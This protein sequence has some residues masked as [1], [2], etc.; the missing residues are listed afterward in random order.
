MI[1]IIRRILG[2]IFKSIQPKHGISYWKRRA[3]NF[4]VRSVLNISHKESE[5]DEVTAMQVREIFPHLLSALNGDE[6]VVLD[7]GC[8]PGRFTA[9]LAEAIHGQAIGVDPIKELL[10]LVPSHTDKVVFKR[11]K[12][13]HIPLS[14]DSVDVVWCCLV[15]GGIRNP[16]LSKCINEI[17]RILRPGGLLFLVENTSEKTNNPS[18]SWLFHSISDYQSM[19]P[20]INLSHLHNYYDVGERISVIA[21][22]MNKQ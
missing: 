22:R 1:S 11:M 3:K 5:M 8:G 10:K 4:G 7:F 13:T 14:D 20:A 6:Q 18:S 9:K 12:K 21:G 17:C 2:K 15:L 19:F 16:A